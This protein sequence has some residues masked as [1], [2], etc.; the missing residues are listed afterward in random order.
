MSGNAHLEAQAL[1]QAGVQAA[2]KSQAAAKAAATLDQ[3][4][5]VANKKVK[6]EPATVLEETFDTRGP[7]RCRPLAH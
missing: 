3:L 5:A 7:F 1:A 6:L 4:R 2:G